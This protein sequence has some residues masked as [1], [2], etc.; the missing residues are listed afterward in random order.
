MVAQPIKSGATVG[1]G[2]EV[3]S[4]RGGWV[5]GKNTQLGVWNPDSFPREALEAHATLTLSQVT[6]F[7]ALAAFLAPICPPPTRSPHP[8]RLCLQCLDA[9]CHGIHSRCGA[10]GK[11][12]NKLSHSKSALFW[13]PIFS[14]SLKL[15][16]QLPAKAIYPPGHPPGTGPVGRTPGLSTS[17]GYRSLGDLVEPM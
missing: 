1:L 15:C 17:E 8:P 9:G 3:G 4:W 11:Y 7:S 10:P 16:I 5:C 6:G 14:Y 12:I 2:Q 13:S